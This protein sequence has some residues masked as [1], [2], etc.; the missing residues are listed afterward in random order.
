MTNVFGS[1]PP[2]IDTIFT[3]DL[4]EL[5][6]AH[7]FEPSVPCVVT[8]VRFYVADAGLSAQ[9]GGS[10][11]V[12]A[13]RFGDAGSVVTGTLTIPATVGW[14]DA[15]LS[16]P[17]QAFA[18]SRVVAAV[19]LD[20]SPQTYGV[21]YDALPVTAG[22]LTCTGSTYAYQATHLSS[23]AIYIL[24]TTLQSTSY[25]IDVEAA[26]S[27]F[28]IPDPTALVAGDVIEHRTHTRG[29]VVTNTPDTDAVILT[30]TVEGGPLDGTDID[31]WVPDT[32]EGIASADM[33]ILQEVDDPEVPSLH[34]ADDGSVWVYIGGGQYN[35][36][37]AGS[38][39]SIGD[40]TTRAD[41]PSLT[42]HI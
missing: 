2:V 4:G 31:L 16:S 12:Q 11:A 6:L 7:V 35:C 41:T 26:V 19:S 20:A 30:V 3:D 1:E 27:E 9:L 22:V 28:V 13:W 18:D 42:P 25:L 32:A 15:T 34:D 8:K 17:L 14:V 29:T 24:P 38:N 23:T 39:F 21:I 33:E 36:C 40:T 10:A 37:V 5:Q